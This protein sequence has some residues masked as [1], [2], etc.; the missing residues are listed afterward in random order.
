MKIFEMFKHRQ[1]KTNLKCIGLYLLSFF[2]TMSC[3]FGLSSSI[4]AEEIVNV[5]KYGTA[6][7]DSENT[8]INLLNDENI[9]NLWIAGSPNCPIN[10]GIKL[11]GI[12]DVSSVKIYFEKQKDMNQKIRFTL[13]YLDNT[14]NEY[15]EFYQGLNFNAET[16][17]YNTEFIFGTPVKTDDIKV[18]ITERLEGTTIW[19]AI[20]EI[21]IYAIDTIGNHGDKITN[22]AL[23]KP[24]EVSAGTNGSVITDG[25]T[26][27]FWDGGAAPSEFIIDLG[28]GHFVSKFKA[29]TYYGDNRYYHYEIYGSLDGL[30]Y[31]LL[32]Q[33]SNNNSATSK[34]ETY[35]L[36]E[37]ANIRYV[38]V[39]MTYNSA[40]PSVH[41]KEFEVWGY[42]DPDYKEPEI[43]SDT[44]YPDN[45]AYGKPAR[46][47]VSDKGIE[48]VTDGSDSTYYTGEFYPAAI[49]VDLM[50]EYDLNKLIINFPVKEGRYYYY[51][52]YGSNDYSTF[53]ELYQK[54]D[55]VSTT[56]DGDIIDL[57][58]LEGLKN[59]TYR[60]I[61]VYLEYCSDAGSARVSEIRAFGTPTGENTEQ[62]RTGSIEDILGI[63]PF[64]E[65]EYASKITEN[66]TI[67]NVYGIIDRTVGSQYRE[68]FSF[69]LID[70]SE[71]EDDFYELSMKDGKIHISGNEGVMLSAG[72]NF[73]YKNYCNVNISEQANQT[74]M[75]DSIV[76]VLPVRKTT[77]YKVR[78]A[79]NYCT[80]DYT[81]AFFG[82]DDFQKEYDWLALNGVN[83]VLDLA[84]QEAVWINFLMNYNYSFDEA[85]DWL[86]GP[87]YYAWQFMDNLEVFGGPVSDRWVTGRLEMAREN[88]RWKRS[89]GIDTVLQ[90]YAGMVP[91]NFVDHQPDAEILE[92]GGWCGLNR[93][94]MIRTD[95]QLY[96]EYAAAF[97]KAQEWAF[98]NTSD[99]YAADPFHEGG[100]RPSDLSDETIATE[101]LDSLLKY[102]QDAVWMVQAW[103]SNPTNDLLKGMG[104][105][106]QDHVMILDLTGLE[107]PKWDKT[108]YGSTNLDAPEFNGT[109]WVWCMLENY[110]GNPSMDGQLAKIAKDIPNAYKEAKHMKGI[111]IIAEAQYDNPVIYDLIWDMAWETEPIDIDDWLDSYVIR[112]YGAESENARKAWDLLEESVY[113]RSGNTPYTLARLPE[114][115]GTQSV[116]YNTEKLERA[117]KLLL[118]DFDTLS[119]SE[120][121][122]YD[123][124]EI[125]RQS[126][127]NYAV[128]QYNN[129][130]KAYNE[131]DLERFRVEKEKFLNSFDV[132]DAVQSTQV[133]QLVGEWIGKAEDW[134]A[135]DDDFSKNLLPMNAKALITTWA[136]AAS[137]SA[138]PDYAYRNYQG[139]MIDVYKTRWET[140]LDKEE[141]Y[142]I[143][144]TPV[145]KLNQSQYFHFYWQWVMNTPEYTREANNSS[146]QVFDVAQKVLNDCSVIVERPENIGNIAI[147]KKIW[148]NEER[149]S[150]GSGGGYA[151]NAND[152]NPDTYWDGGEWET[153][154]PWIILDLGKSYIVDKINILPYVG[155][156]Y[157][158]YDLFI[159]N[160]GENWTQIEHK[161]DQ[162]IGTDKGD[163][164]TYEDGLQARY[165]KLSGK[166]NSANESFHIKEIRA[167]GDDYLNNLEE[168]ISEAKKI[169]LELYTEESA[170]QLINAITKAEILIN[171]SVVTKT[172][173]ENALQ[174]IN[175][176]IA[177]L[178]EKQ[179]NKLALQVAVETAKAVSEETLNGV[180]PAVAAEFRA[181]LAEA[182]AILAD[183]NAD[184]NTIDTSF[185]RLAHAIQMLDF[186]KGDKTELEAL[187]NSLEEYKE[188]N[189]TAES[190]S[191]LESAKEEAVKVM[192]DEN[193]L[194]YEVT[195]AANKLKD[196]IG[197]LVLKADKTLLQTMYDKVEGLDKT[198]YTSES[199]A[200]LTEPMEKAKEVLENPNATQEEI[201][202]AYE[203]LVKA[204]LELRLIP[205]KG[206][207]EGLINKANS[208]KEANYTAASWSV[209][210]PEL[211]K[212]KAVLEN[213]NATQEEIEE[214]VKGLTRAMSGLVANSTNPESTVKPGDTKVK[215]TKTGDN[216]LAGVFAGIAMLSIAG[217]SILRKKD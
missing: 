166:Y 194:E 134:A 37:T 59:K 112:R 46:C 102:D 31:K 190:W 151:S 69:E 145:D 25:Q 48:K 60:F 140:F 162:T 38:Q 79:F 97:Y 200:K 177:S 170:S 61:R 158:L 11:D 68:W 152:G 125:M 104:E 92:Q 53:D 33:K 128:A 157:Y 16:N 114:N 159:S 87:S 132:C 43:T 176:A 184:Q 207:L 147:D 26:S 72:L 70:I 105:Y 208:L 3:C 32:A 197:Q 107:A 196:A 137:A 28:T 6:Y 203:E 91:T 86:S 55:Q 5:A 131:K 106:R 141:Q 65:T 8:S 56:F 108:N 13:S 7:A 138:L 173:V 98:G 110:G 89:L 101:V 204:Y 57:S 30:N 96:D 49:D 193:A 21:E 210:E 192:E 169:N 133:D 52:V 95:S 212:A 45:I 121:Y 40:N 62:L 90:G 201:N 1:I 120:A 175:D 73:Y 118:E 2:I 35:E 54:R 58:V 215:A 41:M 188:E 209:L 88:Q 14:T 217:I 22:I 153:N 195:E 139:M 206:L 99:Y 154:D 75:P 165:I 47:H 115:V 67:E 130:I 80:M 19:P 18:T 124:T 127:N 123:L 76:E 9:N 74:R 39:V 77:P 198:K 150:P 143:D 81:F 17:E 216:V 113:R 172:E 155:N 164:Y 83:V 4:Y 122:L 93:P 111:G 178:E 187:L 10:A 186:I 136:G 44:K 189:Y 66:E 211:E 163:I 119:S 161:T 85:K 78:Y 20:S 71:N 191:V 94:D 50:E 135:N 182:K 126:V 51:T 36:S 12:Y 100:I 167:Y 202:K 180:V 205:D 156:R 64:N 82:A 15:I 63:K 144:S 29:L 183:P 179:L 181:A 42:P 199:V 148:A 149:N 168:K 185:Y 27:A 23:N 214:A 160:D 117:L 146:Q 142:L 213:P 34:G 129:V 174:E 109:D 24:V 84:G 116:G 103:W 171:S